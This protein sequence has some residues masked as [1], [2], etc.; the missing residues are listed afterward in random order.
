[1]PVATVG[2]TSSFTLSAGVSTQL[3]GINPGRTYLLI[4]NND[5]AATI[6][7][8]FGASATIGSIP[9]PPGGSLEVAVGKGQMQSGVWAIAGSGTPVCSYTEA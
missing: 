6:Y 5:P 9:I 4:T 8:S 7:V 3:A 2:Y 1:M